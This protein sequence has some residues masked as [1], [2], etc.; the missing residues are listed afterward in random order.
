MPP[1]LCQFCG[2]LIGSDENKC[3]QCG[4]AKNSVLIPK[5]D[6]Y[7]LM[8]GIMIA[9]VLL[10]IVS[11]AMNLDVVLNP[12]GSL[13]NFGSP[14][15]K[16]LYLLGM[17]GDYAWNRGYVW[18]LLSA[19]FLHGSF[20]HI[21]FNLSWLSTLSKST[22]EIFGAHRSV[23]I[24]VV[25]GV[26]GFLL[27]NTIGD[28]FTVILK[29]LGFSISFLGDTIIHSN[30]PTIGAS[31]S[32]FGLMG[33]LIAFGKR[34]G[35]VVGSRIANQVWA[36]VIIGY[37]FGLSLDGIN[38]WGHTGGFIGGLALGRLF[39]AREGV[40]ESPWIRRCAYV[41]LLLCVV[42]VGLSIFAFRSI[43]LLQ[44]PT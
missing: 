43:F 37:I 38:N 31:C 30:P 14:D 27:S 32:I 3:F 21:L 39:P 26:T 29:N 17:T 18:T 9:C 22:V 13:W 44:I 34:R 4:R 2:Q 41:L 20:L 33:A 24:F 40:R 35:G 11:L 36:W 5:N 7:F 15:G 16:A 23:I 12:K 19:S 8:P 6:G 25:T 1:S 42:S 10:Y 28:I